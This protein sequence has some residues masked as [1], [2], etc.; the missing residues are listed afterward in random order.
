MRSSR[1]T[2]DPDRAV[3]DF[4]GWWQGGGRP[5]VERLV[6]EG[7]DLELDL[8]ELLELGRAIDPDLDWVIESDGDTA[9]LAL[10]GGGD[11]RLRA[12]AERWRSA[13]VPEPPGSTWRFLAAA[14]ASD[15]L[16]EGGL[17]V[18]GVLVDP[19]RGTFAL[20]EVTERWL[21]PTFA[22]PALDALDPEVAQAVAEH[23]VVTLLGEDLV[24]RWVAEVRAA[25][26]IGPEATV[27]APTALADAVAAFGVRQATEEQELVEDREGTER[28]VGRVRR[29]LHWVDTPTA[30]THLV[31]RGAT[32][33]DVEVRAD[34]LLAAL[35]DLLGDAG[36]VVGALWPEDALLLH[37]YAVP[38][39]SVRARV[40][41]WAAGE[42]LALE[43]DDEP[44][45]DSVAAL[46]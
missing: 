19:A 31:L 24:C 37:A 18:E 16:L 27:V 7:G 32:D 2:P 21:V 20:E 4:W 41:A 30:T 36:V 11:P 25:P 13:A 33:A 28:V 1:R 12:V 43:V 15:H 40:E 23:V 26:A 42:R 22:H 17:E 35:T 34:G 3:G 38:S 14:P 10:S 45:W 6:T 44:G 5:Q 8:P 39:A 29:P 46:V 9:T